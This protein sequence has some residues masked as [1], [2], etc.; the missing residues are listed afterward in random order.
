MKGIKTQLD[1]DQT[2]YL[3]L[4][5]KIEFTPNKILEFIFI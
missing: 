2:I 3:K 1:N 4:E 5:M